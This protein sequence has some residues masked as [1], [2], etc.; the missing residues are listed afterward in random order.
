[1]MSACS[2]RRRPRQTRHVTASAGGSAQPD[3]A[4]GSVAHNAIRQCGVTAW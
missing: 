4:P 2:L 3:P 1:M